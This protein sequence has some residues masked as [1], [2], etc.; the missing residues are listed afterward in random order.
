MAITMYG[1]LL[2]K[3]SAL[4]LSAEKTTDQRTV[5]NEKSMKTALQFAGT[6]MIAVGITACGANQEETFEGVEGYGEIETLMT[7]DGT[8]GLQ[9]VSDKVAAEW[10]EE[11]PGV[12][13]H[14]SS[15]SRL[16]IEEVQKSKGEILPD[17][18]CNIGLYTGPSS[19]IFGAAGSAS[20]AQLS[21]TGGTITFTVNAQS[22][23]NG[24]CTTS[25]QSATPGTN[26]GLWGNARF[27]SGSCTADVN[28]IPPGV[29]R[30]ASFTCG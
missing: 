10:T 27:G 17:V 13:V 22:C 30:R 20:L 9:F 18:D 1:R 2:P 6:L 23:V 3:L 28:T 11:A 15:S 21:C 14:K 24:T 4:L 8:H 7:Y 19:P 26:P 16:V 5:E 29:G 25:V 12:Y